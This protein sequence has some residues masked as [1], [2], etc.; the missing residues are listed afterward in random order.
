M[1]YSG[2]V[3]NC[4]ADLHCA[5]RYIFRCPNFSTPDPGFR[6]KKILDPGS[7]IRIKDLFYPKNGSKL[8]EIGSGMFIP[9]TGSYFYPSWILDPGVRKAPDPGSRIPDRICNTE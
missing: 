1:F 7:G 2:M 8:L 6:V 9:D 3:S 4:R 5:V